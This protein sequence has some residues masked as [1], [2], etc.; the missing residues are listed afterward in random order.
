[1]VVF[2]DEIGDL[3][4]A[5]QVKLLRVLQERQFERLGGSRPILGRRTPD[6]GHQSGSGRGGEGQKISRGSL[7]SAKC[8]VSDR[9]PTARTPRRYSISGGIFCCQVCGQVQGEIEENFS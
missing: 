4:P 1:G 2:L 3:A 8:G 5:V 9:P 6:R 7:L